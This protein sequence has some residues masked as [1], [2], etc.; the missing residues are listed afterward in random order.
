MLKS[1][2]EVPMCPEVEHTR[3]CLP[4]PL[5]KPRVVVG[6]AQGPALYDASDAVP[7]V[8]LKELGKRLALLAAKDSGSQRCTAATTRL[9]EIAQYGNEL[10]PRKEACAAVKP[11][12]RVL[13]S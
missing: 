12:D 7:V 11:V 8:D 5:A 1:P 3:Q 9:L 2:R 13:Q 6:C 10:A 4:Q